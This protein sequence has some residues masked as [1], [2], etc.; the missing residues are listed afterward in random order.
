MNLFLLRHGIAAELGTPGYA[1]DN[2]RPLTPK[3]RRQLRETAG[4]WRKMELE[5]DLILTSPLRRA[6]ETASVL[7]EE[8]DWKLRPQVLAELSPG[9]NPVAVVQKILARQPA[10]TNLLLV[11]HEPHLSRLISLLVSG[12]PTTGAGDTGFALK[13]GGLAKLGIEQLHP[14]KCATLAWLLTPK[15]LRWMA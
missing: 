13:K 9:R 8:L 10:P 15:Q 5:F 2:A 14:Q 7:A 1:S 6:K 11:G 4:A 3:G 12:A